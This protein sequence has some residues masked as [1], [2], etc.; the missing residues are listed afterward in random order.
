MIDPASLAVFFTAAL[1]LAMLPG[2]DNLFVLSQS[3][4]GGPA[5]GFMITLGLCTGL[6]VH[7]TAVSLGVAALIKASDL[8]FTALKVAGAGYLL[9]LAWRA[10]RASG[11]TTTAGGERLTPGQFYRRGIIMNVSNPKVT[12]FFPGLSATVYRS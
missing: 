4:I 12:V 6:L 3:L 9:Y 10:F 8:A 2:P 5:A 7:I 1:L 11:L